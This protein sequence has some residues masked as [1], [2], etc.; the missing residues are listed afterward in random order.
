M[1]KITD[2]DLKAMLINTNDSQEETID[3]AEFLEIPEEDIQVNLDDKLVQDDLEK[4]FDFNTIPETID[5]RYEEKPLDPILEDRDKLTIGLTTSDIEDFFNYV[6][7]KG[8]K[9]DFV[10]KFMADAEGRLKEMSMIMMMAQLSRIPT[11][12]ALVNQMTE[13]L[14]SPENLYDMDSKTLTSAISN[15]NKDIMNV[16]KASLETTQTTSQFGSLNNEYRQLLDSMMMLPPEKLQAI[17][18]VVLKNEEDI[19]KK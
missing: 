3:E 5:S 6:S 9:P 1:E 8:E 10:D 4:E 16:L 7:G 17:R 15:M 13:R 14:F 18:D 12:T 2:D 11:Q 19:D